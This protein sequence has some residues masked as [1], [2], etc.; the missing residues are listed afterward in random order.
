MP[1]PGAG[2]TRAPVTIQLLLVM[3]V[4]AGQEPCPSRVAQDSL[5]PS[6]GLTRKAT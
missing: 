3:G 4:K 6:V 2:W 1:P 5:P